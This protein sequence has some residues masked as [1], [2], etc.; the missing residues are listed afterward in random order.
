MESPQTWV[1]ALK[2]NAENLAEWST[3]AP[4]DVP[5]LVWCLEN[6]HVNIEDYLAWACEHYGLPILNSAFFTQSFK[7]ESLSPDLRGSGQWTPWFFPVGNWEDVTL[8][9]CIEPPREALE[10][11][12]AFVLAD[13]AVMHEIWGREGEGE[14]QSVPNP[15][16]PQGVDLNA[17]TTFVLDLD[18]L[19]IAGQDP[20][21]IDDVPEDKPTVTLN[22]RESEL[23]A[24]TAVTKPLPVKARETDPLPSQPPPAPATKKAAKPAAVTQTPATKSAP[25]KDSDT[26]KTNVSPNEEA[27]I[28]IAFNALRKDYFAALLMKCKDGIAKP[29][30]WDT[31][32]TIKAGDQSTF[33]NL[34]GPSFLRIVQKT[35]HPYH[36]YII[37]SPVHEEFFRSLKLAN[38]PA[39]VT[40]IPLAFGDN[41]WGILIAFGTESTQGPHSLELAQKVAEKLVANCGPLWLKS[42]A[43]A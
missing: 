10:G 32:L 7:R 11:K 36:G 41:L 29:Y 27:E 15:E 21:L 24:T 2:I 28:Q 25:A 38:P 1:E 6:G 34:K 42:P 14:S 16:A 31:S 19:T 17:P 35:M 3:Q 13:P 39:S 12:F 22:L 30:K 9:A 43:A 37:E 8:I 20:R 26:T 18:N 23:D 5:V 33:V 4:A 40:A